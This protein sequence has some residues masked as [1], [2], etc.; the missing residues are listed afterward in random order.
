MG[1]FMFSKLKI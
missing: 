1:N